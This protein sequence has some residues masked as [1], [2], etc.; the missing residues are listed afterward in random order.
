MCL[1]EFRLTATKNHPPKP[2]SVAESP[3]FTYFVRNSGDTKEV[4]AA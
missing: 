3:K 2:N 4:I 1:Q